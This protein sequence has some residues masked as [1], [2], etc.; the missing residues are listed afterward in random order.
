MGWVDSNLN[1]ERG[2]AGKEV[3]KGEVAGKGKGV[4]GK[5]AAKSKM[6]EKSN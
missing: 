1:W 5:G 6:K 2:I 4:A 3:E